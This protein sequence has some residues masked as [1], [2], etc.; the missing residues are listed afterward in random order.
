MATILV[1]EDEQDILAL[2]EF[3]L[4]QAGYQV[5]TAEDGRRGLELARGKQPDLV[6][7]DLMLPEMDG[8]EVC[9]LLRQ[10]EHTRHL[11]IV[12]LTALAEETDRVVGFELGADD[13]I[14]K[15]FSP[16]ELVLR[17]RAVLRRAQQEPTS[18]AP[19]T[20]GE[21]TI[22]PQRHQVSVQGR[23]V[24]LTATE[25]KLLHYLARHAGRVQTREMLLEKVWGYDYLGYAR[26]VD[27]HVRRLRKKLG[28]ASGLIETV[29]GLGYRFR[30]E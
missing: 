3:N 2:I 26:T 20:R 11:P 29:R 14:T 18:D 24:E 21:I 10:D 1:V 25:F 6:V 8:R 19:I 13:Y 17:V 28:S 23:P 7:L 5:L 9:R 12:M 16:R 4:R 30:E 15:P 22:D 27:T